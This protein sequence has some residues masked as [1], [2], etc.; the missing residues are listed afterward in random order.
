[1]LAGVRYPEEID[2]QGYDTPQRWRQPDIPIP[3]VLLLNI[4]LPVIPIPDIPKR[5]I[6]ISIMFAV[7]LPNIPIPD[8]YTGF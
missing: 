3:Y 1:M 5:K 6:E 2:S 4:P 7:F 8:I